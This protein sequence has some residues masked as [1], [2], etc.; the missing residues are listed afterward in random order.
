VE[1]VASVLLKNRK[2]DCGLFGDFYGKG[3][4]DMPR[5]WYS[6][7]DLNKRIYT[8]WHH[9]LS[10]CYSKDSNTTT[11]KDCYVCT[12]WLRLSNFV[13]DIEKIDGYELWLSNPNSKIALDKDIKSNGL[14]KEYCLEQCMFVTIGD[15]TRQAAKSLK[16]VPKQANT[17]MKISETLKGQN[18]GGNHPKARPIIGIKIDTGERIE[19]SCIKDVEKDGFSRRGVNKCCLKQQKEHKG[20]KWYYKSNLEDEVHE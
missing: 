6:Q 17:K 16:G 15:N 19:Y 7:S 18:S 20:Y 11:Y 13:E 9:M 10:R 3:I 2:G 4:N 12:R 8:C 14:N 1:Q 5:G